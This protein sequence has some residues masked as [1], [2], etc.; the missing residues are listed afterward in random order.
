MRDDIALMIQKYQL[1]SVRKMSDAEK[2]AALQDALWTLVREVEVE[3]G[4]NTA[5]AVNDGS[6]LYHA[7]GAANLLLGGLRPEPNDGP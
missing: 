6:P 4:W 1:Q 2:I 7:V 3:A 5:E